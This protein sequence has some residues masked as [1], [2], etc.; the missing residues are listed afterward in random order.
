VVVNVGMCM[1][2]YIG[3]AAPFWVNDIERLLF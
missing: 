1:Q 2:T 3:P